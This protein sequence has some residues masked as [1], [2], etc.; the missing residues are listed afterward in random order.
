MTQF[1]VNLF[2][3]NPAGQRSLEDVIGIFGKQLR[4]LGHKC[5]W[6]STRPQTFV[7][8]QSGI[9]VIVEGFTPGSIAQIAE[10]YSKGCRFL[11]LATEEPIEGKGF[12]HGKELEMR[13]R[14]QT[15]PYAMPYF[16][17]IL[18]L[19]PGA[20]VQKWYGALKP[21]AYVEL[22]Y[23]PSLMRIGFVQPTW[24]FGFY[25]SATDRRMRILKRLAKKAGTKNA[26]KIVADFKTQ[27]ERDRA[28]QECRVIVQI[29]KYDEMG[30]VSSSRC[31]TAICIGRPVIAEPHDLS[32]E[33]DKVVKFS[34]TLDDFYG[35][36]IAMRLNWKEAHRRQLEAFKKYF[37][38]DV[39][40]GDP[41][42][43]IGLDLPIGTDSMYY[44]GCAP[45][46]V[47]VE[48]E[49]TQDSGGRDFGRQSDA[50][51]SDSDEHRIQDGA[52][53]LPD[54]D[55]R[56]SVSGVGAGAAVDGA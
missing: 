45:T 22:G 12:N 16:E 20:H 5:V 48:N 42:K 11:C 24:D 39:C 51:N 18:Y 56:L 17:G 33:W 15:F 10:M 52:G 43:K 27:V 30:L 31:N 8:A 44:P 26:I 29:R 32:G 40:V 1:V 14:M 46:P 23:A 28:M 6:D 4:A 47:T 3:H 41:L 9:N 34:K 2:N 7:H 54:A 21:S 37:P 35:D 55:V 50:G 36:A 19:V 13:E 38:P 53:R 25:G 49:S